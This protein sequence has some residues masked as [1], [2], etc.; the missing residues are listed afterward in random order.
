MVG[1]LG[2]EQKKELLKYLDIFLNGLS[3]WDYDP[4]VLVQQAIYNNL[5]IIFSIWFLGLTVIGVP[6][7]LLLLFF[8][9]FAMGFTIGFLVRQKALQGLMISLL[10]IIP[11]SLINI[12]ATILGAA[13]AI[14]FSCWLVK[15]RDKGTSS[16]LQQF[17]AYC[18]IMLVISL[19]VSVMGLVE[20]LISPTFI[21]LITDYTAL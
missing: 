12:P 5:K 13:A 6:F 20:A 1:F 8:R 3:Q 21:K 10:A 7:I 15:G 16:I 2:P 11:P 9:G 17:I 14:S 4:T 18:F 19:L